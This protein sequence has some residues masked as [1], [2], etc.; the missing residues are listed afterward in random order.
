MARNPNIS[1]VK[2]GYN[3]FAFED[4][5]TA[6]ELMALMSKVVC[7]EEQEWSLREDTLCTH[8]LAEDQTLPEL[9][10]VAANKFNP[11]ETVAE[12][13]ARFAREKK[14]RED[15]D[16]QFREAPP[17]LTVPDFKEEPF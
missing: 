13:K 11:H 1:V 14:D 15:M 4:A 17:A 16:Q 8:F 7:V 6:L 2:I 3:S 10:F 12:A 5:Q 9:K